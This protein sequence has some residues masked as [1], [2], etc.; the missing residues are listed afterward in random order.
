MDAGALP[1]PL[2]LVLLTM[3]QLLLLELADA[4]AGVLPTTFCRV[5]SSELLLP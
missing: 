3:L 4:D 5:E 2:L 1:Y